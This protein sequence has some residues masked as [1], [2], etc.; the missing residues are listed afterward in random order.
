M[1][2]MNGKAGAGEEIDIFGEFCEPEVNVNEMRVI[3]VCK[4]EIVRVC[5]ALISSINRCTDMI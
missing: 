4:E 2:D 3:D 1:D 5:V